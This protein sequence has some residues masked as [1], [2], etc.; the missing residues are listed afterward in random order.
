MDKLS[1][2]KK[3]FKSVVM[4]KD[5]LIQQRVK[6]LSKEIDRDYKGRTPIFL[7]V[8]N[9]SFMFT[10]DLLRN[11]TIDCSVEFV[12]VSSYGNGMKSSGK[13]KLITPIPRTIKNR[14]VI[15][16][17]DI[18]DT[19]KTLKFIK[20]KVIKL[21]PRSLRIISLLYKNG[22]TPKDV[23]IDYIGFSIPN[24]FI[25]GYGLDYMQRMRNLKNIYCLIE[26][27]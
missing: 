26:Y 8:L 27:K 25:V 1:A 19:E 7:S 2:I 12:K 5:S 20:N 22:K 9:G 11:L 16:I 14:D 10:A 15:I 17:E 18:I 6:E 4:I 21:N 24:Y 13:I 3:K 23:K